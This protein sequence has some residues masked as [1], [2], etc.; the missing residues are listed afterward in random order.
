[1]KQLFIRTKDENTKNTLLENGFT[2]LNKEGEFY[3]FIND[4][5]VNFSQEVQKE[6]FYTDKVNI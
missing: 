4:G 5:K 3:I 1:M 2:L 6:I